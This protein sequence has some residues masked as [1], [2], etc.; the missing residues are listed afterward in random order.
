M[1]T[2][3]GLGPARAG[4]PVASWFDPN[5]TSAHADSFPW[6]QR[7]REEGPVV[8]VPSV[9][10]YAVT[11]HKEILE[12]LRDTTT[13]SNAEGL[14]EFRPPPPAI[15]EQVGEDWS[16]PDVAEAGLTV[17]DPP[18]HTRL[19]KI[20]APA[21]TPRRMA[22]HEPA[23]REIAHSMID[24][25]EDQGHADL[26]AQLAYRLPSRVIGRIIGAEDEISDRFVEWVDAFFRLRLTQMSEAEEIRCW[27]SLLEYERFCRAL[28]DDRRQHPQDD[29]T[30]DLIYARG[31]DGEPKLTDEQILVLTIGWI[32]AGAETS[33][34]MIVN[35]LQLLL[36]H[37]E[38]WEQVRASPA[39]AS[40]A[41][42]EALRLRSPIRGIVRVVTRDTQL[43]GVQ[44]RKGARVYWVMASANH[45]ERVFGADSNKFDIHRESLDEHLSFGKWAHYCIGAPLARM[46]GRVT[47]QALAERLPKLRLAS[48][49]ERDFGYED[50]LLLP[51][52]KALRVEWD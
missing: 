9:G 45:D 47:I 3:T 10:M 13:F 17:M 41:L 12:I 29:L 50:N 25:F 15:R 37:R 35:A 11:R 51:P 16:F 30:T 18:R 26:S 5:E 6:Y 36:T 1:S 31:D 46:E 38:Q 4:C 39:L 34:I 44:I 19:R 28:I 2:D 23:I 33:S 21:L 20:V 42:E 8:F 24:E 48:D 40:A 49:Y 22:V 43:A 32:G 7:L 52:V 14:G 27:R